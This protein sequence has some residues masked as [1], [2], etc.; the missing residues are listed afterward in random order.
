MRI[1]GWIERPAVQVRHRTMS[2]PIIDY[3]SPASR[4][5]LRLPARSE[6]RWTSEPGRRLTVTQVLSG[7]EGAI[8]ALAL[9]AFTFVIMS[10]SVH[11]MIEKWQRFV[12]EI[13]LL[14]AFMAAEVI[15]G[16]LVINRTWRKTIL[17]VTPEE[18]TLEFTAPFSARERFAFRGEQ[19]AQVSVVDRAGKPGEAVVPELEIRMWSIPP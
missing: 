5:S 10:L 11:G 8:G 1:S 2:T 6:I 9:A 7:R 17:T 13:A 19:V 4:A 14:G 12:G 3:A 15:L 16:A 18:M